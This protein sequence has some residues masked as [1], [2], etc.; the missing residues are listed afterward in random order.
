MKLYSNDKHPYYKVIYP[1][2]FND[3]VK[4]GYHIQGW[5]I[6]NDK[7][8]RICCF[9][10]IIK[11]GYQFPNFVKIPSNNYSFAK[12]YDEYNEFEDINIK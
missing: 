5:W 9:K 7:I 8:K 3:Y 6:I 2:N 12:I 10:I 4:K 11:K 1:H